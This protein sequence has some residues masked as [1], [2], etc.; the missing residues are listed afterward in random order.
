MVI[1]CTNPTCRAGIS[2]PVGRCPVC[3][4][5]L[6]HRLLLA[7]ADG[8]ARELE[9]VLP[10]G[11][12]VANR[13]LVWKHPVWLDTRPDQTLAAVDTIPPEVM[14]YLRLSGFIQHIPRP[15]DYLPSATSG[16]G[17]DVL[18]LEAAPL[19][20]TQSVTAPEAMQVQGLPALSQAWAGGTALQQMNWLRQ[21]ALLWPALA[22]ER[23][24]STLLAPETLR[25]DHALLRVAWLV[26][27]PPQKPPPSLS[28]LG[29]CWQPWVAQAQPAVQA[30]LG[31]LT[32]A[33]SQGSI[34]SA[35]ALAL[36]LEEAIQTL[37]AGLTVTVEWDADTDQGPSRS[38]NEDACFPHRQA[39]KQVLLGK[40][41]PESL[42]LLLVCDGI[43]GHE[44]GNVASQTAIQVLTTVLQ[45]LGQ[46][47]DLSPSTVA[48][49][50]HQALVQV[51]TAIASRNN[52]EQRSA[53]ARMGT[54]AVLALVHFPYVSVAHLGDS[55]AYRVSARTAYQITLD[56]DVAS[57][58]ARLGYALY[59]EATQMA[60]GGA[61]VQAL[62]LHDSAYLYPTVQQFLV[63]DPCVLLLCSDGLSDYDRVEALWPHVLAPLVGHSDPLTPTVQRLIQWANELNG[64]DN[65]T[66]GLMRFLPQT[67]PGP[68]LP[69]HALTSLA[70]PAVPPPRKIPGTPAD[71]P[72]MT[73]LAAPTPPSHPGLASRRQGGWPWWA[74]VAG[75]LPTLLLV[76]GAGWA[77][78]R[79]RPQPMA[80]QGVSPW[81]LGVDTEALAGSALA[82]VAPAPVIAVG[83]FWQR[84]VAGL[85]SQPDLL[86]LSS[87][88]ATPLP[89]SQPA[90][91]VGSILKVVDQRRVSNQD[92]VFLQVCA[93]P[94]SLATA[95]QAQPG[96]QGWVRASALAAQATRL[97]PVAP[98]QRGICSIP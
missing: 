50:L 55:R 67:T 89:P 27:D 53:R 45:S 13:Y 43:G 75:A 48:Q 51:N 95:S 8:V 16:L 54:T 98:N 90:I 57:R 26:D 12:L 36:E 76:V 97:N 14:P 23:V 85:A 60:G 82:P 62:G 77:Y 73:T 29:R 94:P 25:V 11:T 30:Y 74:L 47:G 49:G 21:I 83:T 10:T 72:A 24:T 66:V 7:V 9:S 91:P 52:D 69:A 17:R 63:D 31:W 22:E 96:R 71:G 32:T 65:T 64:H 20:L 88:P 84:S 4:T 68:T 92:W 1:Y 39:Q 3:Q 87:A 35:L 37:A 44:Q 61:L 86:S 19:S 80:L 18:L 28:S 33:L 59:P 70:P 58:E 38:R 78:T 46:Q 5:P 93:L 6:L 34:P 81:L 79:W 15:Y 41:N 42:P 56:D 40:G 2:Q